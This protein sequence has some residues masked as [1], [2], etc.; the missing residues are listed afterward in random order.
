[1]RART[2]DLLQSR[3]EATIGSMGCQRETQSRAAR[4][5]VEAID[6]ESVPFLG[7]NLAKS[8]R[9]GTDQVVTRP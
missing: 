2:G 3:R 8:F 4:D 7:D 6:Y 1:M 9:D 5:S